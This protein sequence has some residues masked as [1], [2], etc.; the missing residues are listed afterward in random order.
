MKSKLINAANALSVIR[1][2]LIPLIVFFEFKQFVLIAFIFIMLTALLDIL[3]GHLARILN[4]ESSLGAVLDISADFCVITGVLI[5]LA[6]KGIIPYYSL[7]FVFLCFA[8]FCCYSIIT[9]RISKSHFGKFAGSVCFGGVILIYLLRVIGE[10]IALPIIEVIILFI[11]AYL[12]ISTAET[13]SHIIK[14]FRQNK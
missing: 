3:D 12:L 14:Q 7:L 2:L 1:I 10:Q 9:H 5:V 11:S 8:T 13:F 4:T 6:V